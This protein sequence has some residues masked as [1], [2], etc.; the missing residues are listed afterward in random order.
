MLFIKWRLEEKE[1][2]VVRYCPGCKSKVVFKDSLVKRHNANGKNIFQFAIYKCDRGHTWN[3]LID[4]Y[5]ADSYDNKSD[6]TSREVFGYAEKEINST[7]NPV[8]NLERFEP[9]A[10]EIDGMGHVRLDKLIASNTEGAN[11]SDIQKMIK[12]GEVLLNNKHVKVSKK[13]RSGD[14]IKIG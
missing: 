9:V 14:V 4:T 6:V 13:V 7:E 8:I 5:Q 3:K 10:I 1:D 12:I 11:R 2:M